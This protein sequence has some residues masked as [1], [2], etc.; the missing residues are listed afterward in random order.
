MDARPHGSTPGCKH[1]EHLRILST[2][3][4][5]AVMSWPPPAPYP[6]QSPAMSPWRGSGP[7]T[8]DSGPRRRGLGPAAPAAAAAPDLVQHEAGVGRHRRQPVDGGPRIPEICVAAHAAAV[9]PPKRWWPARSRWIHRSR[10]GRRRRSGPMRWHRR[11]RRAGPSR[12]RCG[13]R[14]PAAATNANR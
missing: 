13:C 10:T 2:L 12:L 6:L 5:H 1:R 4:A 8:P 14:Q 9:L 7:G 11:D 3:I